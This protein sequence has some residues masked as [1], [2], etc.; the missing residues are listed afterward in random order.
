MSRHILVIDDEEAVRDAFLLALEDLDY[1][2]DTASSGE[3]G[4][5]KATAHKPDLVF[6]DLKMPGL[7]GVQTLQQLQA[8]Y[9]D[10][11]VY[12]VTAFAQEFMAPLLEATQAG[13][14]FQVAQ[15]PL[16]SREIRII[17]QSVF[18]QIQTY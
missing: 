16:G 1:H 9:P 12:I 6:L 4:L 13:L 3:E 10:L 15:K 14:F 8:A 2:I 11:P 5:Q 17:A 18:D 7:N